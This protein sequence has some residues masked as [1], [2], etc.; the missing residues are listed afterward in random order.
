MLG[1]F[2]PKHI[3]VACLENPAKLL[4]ALPVFQ[5]L[6][7]AYPGAKITAFVVAGAEGMFQDHPAIDAVETLLPREALLHLAGRFRAL[8]P[9]LCLHLSP[10]AKMVLAA[11]LGKVPVR[12]GM[13]YRWQNLF[14]TRTVKIN[15][16]VS[17]RN[18]VEYNFEILKP[19]GITKFPVKIDFPLAEGEKTRVQEIL[20]QKGIKTGVPYVLVHPGSKGRARHWK[21]EKFAQ[22]LGHLCQL[23]GLRVVLT[24]EADESALVSEVTSFLYSLTSD[25]KP[26]SVVTGDLTLKELAALCQGAI[27]VLTGPAGPLYLAA[28][29][30]TP[31][32]A[33]F[34]PAPEA[35]P[36]RWGPWGNEY[37]VLVPKGA[38]CPSCQVGYCRKH[39]PMDVLTVPEVFESMKKYIRKVMPV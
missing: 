5:T 24:T 32:V 13:D 20:I 31:T 27:C 34:S 36:E 15:R 12:I 29:V 38:L 11:W 39:D 17:D 14:F 21:A 18:E 35:T 37:T 1:E 7:S 3:L 23:Q 16:A 28:A 33:I 19:L 9:D 22:L 25:Q 4:L 6:R 30:G 10:N 8:A 2:N 26:V